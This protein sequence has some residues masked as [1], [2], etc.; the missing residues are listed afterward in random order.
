MGVEVGVLVG[1]PVGVTVGVSVAVGVKVAVG[2]PVAVGAGVLVG[3]I[4]TQVIGFTLPTQPDVIHSRLLHVLFN[5]WQIVMQFV[6]PQTNELK[7]GRGI[8]VGG[9]LND[10]EVVGLIKAPAVTTGV[11]TTVAVGVAVGVMSIFPFDLVV[12]VQGTPPLSYFWS[13]TRI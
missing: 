13:P 7:V 1:V 10:S 5:F 6:S 9:N 11:G 4:C 3:T 2:A 8:G 12:K